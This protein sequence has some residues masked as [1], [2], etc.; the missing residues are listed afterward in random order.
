MVLLLL[1]RC[2]YVRGIAHL[3]RVH[4][5]PPRSHNTDQI[6][7]SPLTKDRSDGEKCC[8]GSVL[9]GDVVTNIHL[10]RCNL[11]T[12]AHSKPP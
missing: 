7:V 10:H 8:V 9:P 2:M 1:R 4:V 5:C 3:P 11:T 12:I 6:K